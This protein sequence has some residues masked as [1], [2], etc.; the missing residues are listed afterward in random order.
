MAE[1]N[2]LPDIPVRMQY[3]SL[4]VFSTLLSDC[5]LAGMSI[6]ST[7]AAVSSCCEHSWKGHRETGCLVSHHPRE[8]GCLVSH[9]PREAELRSLLLAQAAFLSL[10]SIKAFRPT[11]KLCSWQK[12]QEEL[13]HMGFL[14]SISPVRFSELSWCINFLRDE[15][16][17][18]PC[19]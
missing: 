7:A 17:R 6:S 4:H 11:S 13:F 1:V 15:Q 3:H 16:K 10:V 2:P 9:Q 14:I 8:A 12:V 18:S 5:S 19:S